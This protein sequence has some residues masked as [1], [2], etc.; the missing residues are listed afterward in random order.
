M[1]EEKVVSAIHVKISMSYLTSNMTINDVICK[2]ERH[3][4]LG[5]VT[6]VAIHSSA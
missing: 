4:E 3:H 2:K 1:N 6:Q 5:S